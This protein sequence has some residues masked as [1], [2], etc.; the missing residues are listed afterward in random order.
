MGLW[1]CFENGLRPDTLC[2]IS[3]L[4]D[5]VERVRETIPTAVVV[6]PYK[7][8]PAELIWEARGFVGWEGTP[9]L[10]AK[11][12]PIVAWCVRRCEEDASPS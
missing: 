9:I 6:W 10:R 8:W 3:S 11:D 1:W 4:P 2:V 7:W 12:G 5:A